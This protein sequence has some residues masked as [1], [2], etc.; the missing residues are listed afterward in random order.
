MVEDP[1]YPIQFDEQTGEYQIVYNGARIF[2]EYCFKCGGRL[3]E[4]KR[5]NVFTTP[6]EKELDEVSKLLQGASSIQDV[7]R[8]L[9]APDKIHAGDYNTIDETAPT[10]STR[11]CRVRPWKQQLDYREQWP[12]LW[13]FVHENPDGSVS[14]GVTGKHIASDV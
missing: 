4:T 14:Y 7:I 8:V 3:P 9:G 2:M 1:L 11:N 6:D 12:S 10:E 13:L 5:G